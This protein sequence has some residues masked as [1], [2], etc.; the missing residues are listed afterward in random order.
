MEV[1]DLRF[2]DPRPYSKE[3][4]LSALGPGG[5]G[6][7]TE[8]PKLGP[9]KQV[10]MILRSILCVFRVEFCVI[11][12]VNLCKCVGGSFIVVNR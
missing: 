1:H 10:I 5:D 9:L 8:R 6:I 11:L 12:C 2:L 7:T 4:S 3:C